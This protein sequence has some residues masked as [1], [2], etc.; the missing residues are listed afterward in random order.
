MSGV[1]V[2]SYGLTRVGEH[3]RRSLVDLAAEAA[4][5]ALDSSRLDS[6]DALVV[7]NMMS[8]RLLSQ[9]HLG[10]VIAAELGLR[11]CSAYKVELAQASG[12]AAINVA[13]ALLKSGLY[14]NVLVIGVEKTK[15]STVEQVVDAMSMSESP[16]YVQMQGA[17]VYSI[18]A[19]LTKLYTSRYE[20]GYEKLAYFPVIAHSNAA[21]APH[22]QFRQPITVTK[23][24][25][26]P[27][28]SDPIRLLD[29]PP[30]GD[31]AAALV[32][33]SNPSGAVA[34]IPWSEC[35]TGMGDLTRRENPLRLE[36]LGLAVENALSRSG[37]DRSH[38]DFLEIQDSFSVLAALSL[39]ES[40]FSERGRA[41]IE[42]EEGRF[43]LDGELPIS[44]FGGMKARGCPA[45][46]AGVYQVVEC[47]MQVSGDAG[48]N[49]VEGARAGMSINLGGFGGSVVVTVVRGV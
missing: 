45:G 16:E 27:V 29:T 33:S 21:K 1:Y 13:Y 23:V 40:G 17:N 3:W 12:G 48:G 10:S 34:E 31:G 44:T 42:A 2:K 47:V 37:L 6:V 39:E 41:A 9:E 36:E 18:A 25:N 15:D 22:A 38:I 28:V 8:G 19:I 11:R 49:Q 43:N 20:V 5:N 4:F 32:L 35:L 46:A 26:S 30:I 7:G 24:L 14:E